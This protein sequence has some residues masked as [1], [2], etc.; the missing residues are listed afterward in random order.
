M[1]VMRAF[2]LL[3]NRNKRDIPDRQRI[4]IRS[5]DASMLQIVVTMIRANAAIFKQSKTS[6]LYFNVLCYIIIIVD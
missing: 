2:F 1:P 6:N 5:N 3:V 4:Y